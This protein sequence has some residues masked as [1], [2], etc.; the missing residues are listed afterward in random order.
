ML[1]ACATP[2]PPPTGTPASSPSSTPSGENAPPTQ[3]PT[4]TRNPPSPSASAIRPPSASSQTA[5]SAPSSAAQRA[6]DGL[7]LEQR[8]GQVL[9]MGIPATGADAPTLRILGA[10]HVGNVF[11]KGRSKLGVSGTR[12]VVDAVRATG[13]PAATGG[14]RRFVATDQE[15]GAVQV[16]SGPGFSAM[17]AGIV[18]GGWTADR[19]EASA[20]TWAVELADAGVDVNL[21]PVTD[22]VP[23]AAFAPSNAPIGAFGREFGYTTQTVSTHSLAFSR[24]MKSGGV[25]PVVKHFPGLGRVTAN[26]DTTADVLDTVTTRNDQYLQPFAANIEAGNGWVMV[27]NARYERIDPENIA[28][29]SSKVMEGMLRSDQGFSGIIIS[30]DMCKAVALSAWAYGSRAVNFF[31]AG[32]TMMLCVNAAAI[33][34]ITRALVAEARESSAFRARIDAAALLVLRAKL[35]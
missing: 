13:A 30:D 3:S 12:H 18:Q 31:N 26:T 19:L 23:S 35:G 33:P 10:D 1:S 7:S 2:T 9:M 14:I 6:L 21:A 22:T 20:R 16:L 24:G 11:L 34:A 5:S 29:F 4:S 25:Q 15:G 32:G 8:V 28:P 17:P 27:S